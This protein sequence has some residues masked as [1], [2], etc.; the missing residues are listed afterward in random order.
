MI[1][2]EMIIARRRAHVLPGEFVDLLRACSLGALGEAADLDAWEQAF[3]RA[4]GSPHAALTTTGRLALQA[5]LRHL[6]VGP[7]DEVLVPSYTFAGLL[8]AVM[9]LGARPVPVDVDADS[10]SITAANVSAC[11]TSRT[12]AI[13]VLHAFGAPCDLDPIIELASDSG[14]AV[15]EDCAHS[16]GATLN[17]R[18]TG[19]GGHAGFFSFES[20]KPINTYG[21]GM[22]VT[23]DAELAAATRA[24]SRALRASGPL[25]A[26]KVCG[27]GLERLAFATGIAY[28]L[29]RLLGDPRLQTVGKW[30]Y[31]RSQTPIPR[32]TGYAP[33]QARCGLAK[34]P[35]LEQ[36]VRR[37]AHNAELLRSMLRSDI[38]VQSIAQG[39]QS[40]W[41]AF[42]ARLP[43]PA[44]QVRTRLLSRGIDAGVGGEIMD[45]C[46]A[47]LGDPNCPGARAL[48]SHLIHLPLRGDLS[49]AQLDRI[50]SAV[51]AAI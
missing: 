21:G 1:H 38:H 3:A 28:P 24:S 17:G 19:T 43:V 31:D 18:P 8:D 37:R 20:A 44:Q 23:R 40:S 42:V 27:V 49:S 15:I 14:I 34:L 25:I 39:G 45:D 50:A 9:E 5:V 33:V 11:L 51:N 2:S 47:I 6:G 35:S 46:A 30:V 41:Y 32:S 48:H 36:R 16:L 26:R 10:F 29:L 12:R 7:G 13:V 4:V 22:L